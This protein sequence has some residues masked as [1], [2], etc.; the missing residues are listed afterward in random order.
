MVFGNDLTLTRRHLGSCQEKC[1][2]WLL[3]CIIVTMSAVKHQWE[4]GHEENAIPVL[5]MHSQH[6]LV[7]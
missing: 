4:I 6:F 3:R 5:G 1:A 7:P 2:S